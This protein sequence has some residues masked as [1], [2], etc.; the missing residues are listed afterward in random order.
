MLF[1]NRLI[2][3]VLQIPIYNVNSTIRGKLGIPKRQMKIDFFLK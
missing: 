2:Y 3:S 1:C